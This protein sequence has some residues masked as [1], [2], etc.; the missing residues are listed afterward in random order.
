MKKHLL[1]FCLFYIAITAY[2]QNSIP[3]G[4]FETWNSVTY[5]YPQNYP[6]NSNSDAFYRYHSQLPFNVIKTTDAYHGNYAVQ[7]TT[8]SSATE[9]AFGY[10]INSNPNNGDPSTWTGGMPYNQIPTGIRGY[11]KYNVATGDSATIFAVFSK[12]GSNIGTYFFNIGEIHTDYTLFNFTFS[13]ALPE[14]PD[15]VIF[16]AT[17][18]NIIAS[19]TGVAGSILILDS[20]SFTGVTSQPALMNGDFE[21]WE[22]QTFYKP[23]DWY[24]QYSQGDGISRT[25]DAVAGDYAIELKTFLGNNN[26]GPAA[27]PGQVS[28]GYYPSNCDSNCYELGGYPYS[29]QIDTLAFYYKYAPAN[30]TD[31][32][33]I[34]FGFKKGGSFFWYTGKNLSASADYQYVEIPFNIWQAP[35][36]VV[37]QIQSSNWNDTLV[38]SVGADLKIDEIHFKSQ[39]LNV[40]IPV[41]APNA[42]ISIFPNPSGGKFTIYN[43]V[44]IRQLKVYNILGENIYTKSNSKQQKLNEIDLS[45][46]QKGIYFVEIYDGAKIYTKKI[47]LK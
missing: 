33:Q 46:F 17:S 37:V 38:S 22:S 2:G 9:T 32:A 39:P 10:F 19:Q 31:S 6:Y 36:S 29:N 16:A 11:Y 30:A 27:Q 15:S 4:T 28:T 43:T 25:T 12:N 23:A 13:P 44:G 41:F 24:T 5:D 35:D 21:S 7:L 42:Q 18:S 3:N 26:N 47:V 14:A 1:L 45:R 34:S 20:V 40:S 8:T